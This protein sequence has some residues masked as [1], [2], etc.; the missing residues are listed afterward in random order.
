MTR[1][2]L[3]INLVLDYILLPAPFNRD[4]VTIWNAA[5]QGQFIGYISA[6][7]APT[8]FYI[9]RRQ[10]GIVSAPSAVQQVL[11][12]WQI[13]PVDQAVLNQALQ[14]LFT[15]FEDA[16]Q[17]ASAVAAGVDLIVTRDLADFRAATLPV[18]TPAAFIAR[19]FK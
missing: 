8:I 3:D 11:T 7:T 18:L 6:I 1:A 5:L 19:Q 4:A 14:L 13:C 15:D 16:M 17:L 10:L 2:L 12:A 9:I